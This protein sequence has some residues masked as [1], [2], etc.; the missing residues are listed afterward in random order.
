M[1]N[2]GSVIKAAFRRHD[3]QLA[4]IICVMALVFSTLSRTFLSAGNLVALLENYSV[5]AIMACGLL[6]VLI[7]GGIDI[8]FAAVA[9]VSQYLTAII[10]IQLGG[11]WV[12]AF[13][14]SAGFGFL[15]GIVNALLIYFLKALSVIV[16]ISTMTFYFSM[17]LFVTDGKSLYDLPDWFTAD[18]S[19]FGIPFPIVVATTA[20]LLTVLLLSRLAL[21]L[22]IYALGGNPEAAKRV[23]CNLLGLHCLVYGYSGLVA[24]F[25]GLVEAHRVEEVVP[26]ALIGREL[27]VLAAVVLGGASLLG[28]TGTVS[29]T[30]F[31]I[32]LLAILQNG[33]TLLGVSSYSFGL[34]TGLVIL[35]SVS[36]TAYAAMRQRKRSAVNAD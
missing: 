19:L 3:V 9:A 25:A 36:V 18:L 1:P 31:G 28:G 2:S 22:Q 32:V 21:G 13:V 17:L 26:G 5:M 20:L 35:I 30:I 29:G 12:L 11:N 24:G 33:L 4:G 8:S 10:I 7:S 23:G 6:V 27:D 34:V 14:L 16:T 15:L